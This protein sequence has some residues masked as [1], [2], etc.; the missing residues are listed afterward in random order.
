MNEKTVLNALKPNSPAKILLAIFLVA[1]AFRLWGVTNPLLDFHSWRQTLTAT[2]AKNFYSGDMNLLQPATNWARE[3]YEFEF[4]LYP[5]LVALLYKL[6]GFQDQL[7]RLVSIAFSLG[8]V[9]LLYLLGKRYY[10]KTTGLIAAAT[11]AILPMSVFY[12]RAFMPESA[13]LF[14]SAAMLYCFTRWLE[15]DTWRDFF[16]A[17]L[18]TTLTFLIKLPTLYMGGP[19]LFLACMKF[20]KT[21]F[22]QYK[23]YLFVLLILAPPFLWYSHMADLHAQAHQ[24]ESIWLGNDKLANQ[25][26]L[27]DYKFY[28]LIFWTRLVEKMFAF[29]A[30]PFLVL[31]MLSK[32]ERKE[33]YLFHVW[34]FSVCAYFLIVAVG[35]RVHEYYQIPIIPVGAIFIGV[36][37]AKFFKAHPNPGAWKRD[38]KVGL[39]LLMIVFIPIH[40]IYKLNK[41]LNFNRDYMT[42][43]E[44]IKEHTGEKDRILLQ[45]VGANRPHSFYYSDRKGWTLGYHQ[46]LS[47]RD[48]DQF[49][50]NGAAYYAMA[51]FDLEKVN[52]ELFDYLSTTHK[53]VVRDPL[54]TLFKLNR[55]TSS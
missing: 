30:F 11:F 49:I 39:V 4:Q 55:P 34:F 20:G 47:P 18:C 28:K 7:G 24:G 37:L 35:N 23:L 22:A 33:Q 25:G 50:S 29:T 16:L 51:K 13:M 2:I 32:V 31:G 1:L 27:F 6:F 19:L 52:K 3:Y 40:S 21:I 42:I 26:I 46:N 17:T 41:R 9:G 12:T 15:S 10:D 54:L 45:D 14:F 36:F 48:I 8:T 5:Y 43:G 38:I 44:S 53:L